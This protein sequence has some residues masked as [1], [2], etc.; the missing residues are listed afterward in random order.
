LGEARIE[1]PPIFKD[2]VDDSFDRVEDL[3]KDEGFDTPV[4]IVQPK[5]VKIPQTGEG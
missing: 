3:E 4:V 5:T 2:S 1:P